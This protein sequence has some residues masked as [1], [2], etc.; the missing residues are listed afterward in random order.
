MRYALIGSRRENGTSMANASPPS[1][2]QRDG[3]PS[4]E[5]SAGPTA[6]DVELLRVLVSR[7]GTLVEAQWAIHP[8]L[9]HDL[10]PNEWVEV[11]ELMAKVTHIVGYRFSKV[12]SDVEASHPGHA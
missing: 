10:L 12:L 3:N 4:P 11:N 8:Q 9:R 6:W 2:Q 5:N 7:S 1:G